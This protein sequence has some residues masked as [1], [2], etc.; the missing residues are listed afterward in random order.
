MH[1]NETIQDRDGKK[2]EQII[3]ELSEQIIPEL[4]VQRI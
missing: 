3:P 2:F 4:S 1:G